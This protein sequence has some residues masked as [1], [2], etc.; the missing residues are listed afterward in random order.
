VK[1][2]NGDVS[3]MEG[4]EEPKA[5]KSKVSPGTEDMEAKITEKPVEKTNAN[6]TWL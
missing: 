4:I 3:K 6:G 1:A 5:G 2:E